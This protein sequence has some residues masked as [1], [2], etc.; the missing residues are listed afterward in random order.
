MRK[1]KLR[2]IKISTQGH[3]DSEGFKA[4]RDFFSRG[5]PDQLFHLPW[6][7]VTF[8]TKALW[9][10]FSLSS[11]GLGLPLQPALPLS[12]PLPLGPLDIPEL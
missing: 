2:A 3:L 9:G 12:L 10:L 4:F 6:L 11:E 5:Q 8:R 7:P 1:L